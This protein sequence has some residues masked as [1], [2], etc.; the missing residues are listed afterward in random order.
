MTQK[1]L[2]NKIARAKNMMEILSAVDTVDHGPIA[3]VGEIL[4]QE[5]QQMMGQNT[6]G[7]GPLQD[8]TLFIILENTQNSLCQYCSRT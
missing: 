4:L 2:E 1:I 7:A 6:G 5:E 3:K 8:I